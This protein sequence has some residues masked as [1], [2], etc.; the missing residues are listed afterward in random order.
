MR[1]S[2]R[3][4]AIIWEG[5]DPAPEKIHSNGAVVKMDS[6]LL[7]EPFNTD[8]FDGW[9]RTPP[10]YYDAGYSIINAAC[11]PLYVCGAGFLTT[12]EDIALWD[13]SLFGGPNAPVQPQ[14]W[15]RLPA[16]HW[17]HDSGTQAWNGA[18]LAWPITSLN[19]ASAKGGGGPPV[20]KQ[21]VGAGMSLWS[22]T[23]DCARPVLFGGCKGG[24]AGNC[25]TAGRPGPRVAIVAERSW[26]PE[27][28]QSDV[29][30]RVN[31]GY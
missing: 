30:D 4:Q 13:P 14:M 12:P 27:A 31:C 25:A 7:V 11:A 6:D 15:Q 29:L 23:E 24:G 26:N 28:K 18:T 1:V 2:V 17:F 19:P 22:M 9:A 16:D 10:D 3:G 8:H 20:P 5:F 21:I